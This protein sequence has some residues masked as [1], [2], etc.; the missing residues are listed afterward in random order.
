[1]DWA[2]RDQ[3]ELVAALVARDEGAF[4]WL[5]RQHWSGMM[6]VAT[7]LLRN[8]SLA[9]EV[10]QETWEIVVKE[11]SRFRKESSLST[12]IYRI[13]VN[14]A[15]RVGKKEARAIPLSSFRVRDEEGGSS[16]DE[17]EFTMDG[18]WK[19]PVHGWRMIDPQTEAINKEGVTLLARDLERLPERQRIIVTL[20]DVEGLGSKEVCELLDISEANQ[21]LLLHRGRTRLRRM[22]EA[23]EKRAQL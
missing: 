14:R 12:W 15:R 21:R 17:D 2:E 9:T 8:K 1:V 22:L 5:V 18:R 6:R 11:I 3:E 7:G 20:R 16:R 10:V 19:S 13:M 4:E 23:E